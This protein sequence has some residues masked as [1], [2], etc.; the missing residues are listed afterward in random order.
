MFKYY[1]ANLS[2]KQMSA[3]GVLITSEGYHS[4]INIPELEALVQA[5][6]LKKDK[7]L[8][9]KK[10]EQIQELKVEIP[11]VKEEQTLEVKKEIPEVKEEAPKK[12]KH[13]NR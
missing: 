7:V 13:K 6:I 1:P 9:V 8:E 10:E 11:E 3:N 12:F 5:G 2:I 4:S